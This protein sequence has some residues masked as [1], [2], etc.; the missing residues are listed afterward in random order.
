MTKMWLALW[1]VCLASSPSARPRAIVQ[2]RPSLRDA[3]AS[4]DTGRLVLA[5][6]AGWDSLTIGDTSRVILRDANGSALPASKGHVRW[7]V[8]NT[9]VVTIDSTGLLRAV[10]L[11]TATV[12]ARTP[13]GL[14]THVVTVV[15]FRFRL[16]QITTGMTGTCGIT[17]TGGA[18]CWGEWAGISF[19]PEHE[20]PT[21]VNGPPLIDISVGMAYSCGVDRSGS[22]TCAGMNSGGQLGL[23][24]AN[25]FA[26]GVVHDAGLPAFRS[27]SAGVDY[28]CGI[29]SDSTGYC[30][31][32]NDSGQVGAPSLHERC[33][34]LSNQAPCTTIPLQLPPQYHFVDLVAGYYHTCGVLTDRS[35]VCWGDNGDGQLGDGT[36]KTSS[37]PV[38]VAGNVKFSSVTVGATHTCGVAVDGRGYC[39]GSNRLGELGVGDDTPTHN[40]PAPIVGGMRYLSLS[41]TGTNS[42]CGLTQPHGVACWGLA[43]YSVVDSVDARDQCTDKAGRSVRCARQPVAVADTHQFMFL[44]RSLG[45]A[46]C[47][48]DA[49]GRAFCWGFGSGNGSIH[50]CDDLPSP[51]LVGDGPIC[52]EHVRVD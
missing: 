10:S 41:A 8:F 52:A 22:L 26:S 2:V 34:P 3:I 46:I 36:Y 29:A 37:T 50:H 7:S 33:T 31:G 25:M 51:T 47:A 6:S 19:G 16:S 23:G 30:W 44:G 39:W 32:T 18:I 13:Q 21:R 5:S 45:S 15:P 24:Y 35:V 28:A 42:T 40:V 27:V 43:E 49:E 17:A 20:L 12:V 38:R 48:L 11:G 9:N 1:L 14:A 4:Q